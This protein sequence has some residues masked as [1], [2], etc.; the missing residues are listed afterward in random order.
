VKQQVLESVRDYYANVLKTN[1]DLKT[2]A[3]CPAELPS[4]HMQRLLK[5]VHEAVL[6][7]FYGCGSPLP[8]AAEGLTVLDLVCGAGRDA[9]LL[10]QC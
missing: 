6:V 9:F 8:V 5:N 10:S 7:K 2:S 1:D 4:P 3:C